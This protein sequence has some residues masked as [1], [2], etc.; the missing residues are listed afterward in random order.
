MKSMKMLALAVTLLRVMNG[1]WIGALIGIA[2]VLVWRLVL[3]RKPR[4]SRS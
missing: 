2:L 1:L 4:E 3:D